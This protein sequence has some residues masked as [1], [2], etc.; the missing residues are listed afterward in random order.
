MRYTPKTNPSSP[1]RSSGFFK[2]FWRQKRYFGTLALILAA[3]V[4]LNK[5]E[6]KLKADKNLAASS[7]EL[8]EETMNSG[9]KLLGSSLS[10]AMIESAEASY[11]FSSDD[12][13]E[14]MLM[15]NFDGNG[16][17]A[18]N[19][20]TDGAFGSFRRDVVN[21]TVAEG[22]T[23]FDI[24]AKFN[25]NTDTLLWANN[26]KDGDLI[27]PGDTLIILPINGVRIKTGSKDTPASLAKK[28]SG[29]AEEIIAFNDLENEGAI[30]SG[31]YIIIPNGEMPSTKSVAL[32][33]QKYAPKGTLDTGSW[34][35]APA[36]GKN[37]GRLHCGSGV[38]IAAPCG[39]PIYA[40]AAGTVILSDGVGW[41]SG[42][43]KYI[44]IRHSNGVV[45]LYAHASKLLVSVGQE[46]DQGQLI[47]LMGSTGNSTGC[48]VHWETRG[49]R[50]PLVKYKK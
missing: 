31:T 44:M 34:L 12:A 43:G 8:I 5:T 7:E 16:L 4:F 42:Y 18:P 6:L 25:I 35:I 40:S 41:N 24:A 14:E 26:L 17:I 1:R 39:T 38:D 30:K 22:D 13:L 28:Y 23:P 3:F 9:T 37:W 47:A 45:T 2:W 15:P 20:P 29:K 21:Y 50:N 48:H 33:S 10:S 32:P 19:A 27:R 36:S 46:V 11:D 49:A